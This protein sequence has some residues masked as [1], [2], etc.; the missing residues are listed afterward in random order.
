MNA[1]TVEA[2]I[3]GRAEKGKAERSRV[4]RTRHAEWDSS[5]RHVQPL[6]LLED[7]A[8]TRVPDLVPIRYGRMA[9]SPFAY[10][11]GAAA[12]MAADLSALPRTSLHV[13]LCG[14]AHLANFGGYASPERSFVFDVNDFDETLPGPFEWDVK[15]L[16][17]SLEIAA[18]ARGFKRRE[19]GE[20]VTKAI[21]AY[22]TAMDEFARMSYLDVWYAR[23]DVQGVVDRWGDV[24]GPRVLTALQAGLAKATTKDRLRALKKLTVMV[25]G[26]PRFISSPPLIVPA[27]EVLDAAE[28]AVDAVVQHSLRSYRR[29]LPGDR[30]KLIEKYR[31]VQLARKVVG[32]GSVGRARGLC[33]WLGV[34]RVT[35][36]SCR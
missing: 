9:A 16:A 28:S 18:R 36:S 20:M 21:E 8:R 14:D 15:R 29:T 30:R 31:Y 34:T 27:A 5:M 13:Q 4:P 3:A 25:D 2:P 23:L 1:M 17:A 11:R 22:R 26:E 12:P 33:S 7:Q 35:R 19:R 10:F 32:V 24:A 6:D